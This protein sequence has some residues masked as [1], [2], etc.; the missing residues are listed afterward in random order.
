M[1]KLECAL[2]SPQDIS[3][4][5]KEDMFRLLSRYYAQV[6]IEQFAL[7]LAQKNFVLRLYGKRGE[8]CGFT[9]L[10]EF[11]V[12]F[13]GAPK[14]IIFSGDTIIDRAYWGQKALVAH[15]C[16]LTGMLKG[17]SPETP[18]Y[19]FLICKG[20]RT[21]R[22]LPCFFRRFYPT[23]RFGTPQDVR[24]FMDF[25][26]LGKFGD[27]YNPLRGVVAFEVS[28]GYLR[29]KWRARSRLAAHNSACRPALHVLE[30]PHR[31]IAFFNK[32]NPGSHR[33]DELICLT[34]LSV[35]NMRGPALRAFN[36]GLINASSLEQYCRRT[37]AACA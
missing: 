36:E 35:E 27:Q 29:A 19:W 7:D 28:H 20:H 4:A 10:Q 24:E 5:G 21:Y 12:E 15:W 23:W 14:R 32:V 31:E 26:A 34:E 30:K 13:N 22:F 9:T 16:R 11:P 8:L 33:G 17:L 2:S 3:P 6:S 1:Q 18:L 25:L 37:Q